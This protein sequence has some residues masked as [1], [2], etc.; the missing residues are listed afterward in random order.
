MYFYFGYDDRW[1]FYRV[2]FR[3]AGRGFDS[4][5]LSFYD[6]LFGVRGGCGGGAVGIGISLYSFWVYGFREI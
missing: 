2:C 1:Y 3:F 4:G 5:G 6:G